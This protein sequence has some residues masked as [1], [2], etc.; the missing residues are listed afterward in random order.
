MLGAKN[1]STVSAAR[2][3]GTRRF[4][5]VP[6]ADGLPWLNLLLAFDAIFIALSFLVFEHVIAE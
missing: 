1:A 3:G 5:F 2:R 4:R 6:D